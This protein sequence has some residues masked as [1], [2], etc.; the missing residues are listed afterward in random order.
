MLAFLGCAADPTYSASVA[1]SEQISTLVEVSYSPPEA[2]AWVE[3]EGQRFDGAEGRAVVYGAGPD[4]TLELTVHVGD[5]V[6]EPLVAQTGSLPVE[7]PP[8]TVVDDG[9]L[10][11]RFVLTSWLESPDEGSGVVVLDAAGRVVWYDLVEGVGTVAFLHKVDGGVLYLV[12]THSYLPE[13]H[14]VWLSDDGRD[15]VTY[16]LPMAHHEILPLPGGGFATLVGEARQVDGEDV[17]GDTIVEVAEDGTQRTIWNAFDHFEV[18]ENEGWGV[19]AYP[20]GADW[21]HANGLAYDEA[22][23]RYLVSILRCTCVVAVER[24]TGDIDFIVGGPDSDYAVDDAFGPQ[25]APGWTDDGLSMFDNGYDLGVSRLAEYTLA[26][27]EA[28]LRWQWQHPGG[29]VTAVLGDFDRL[30]DGS[31]LSSW[32]TL[33]EIIYVEA[34]D[35]LSWRVDVEPLHVLGQVEGFESFE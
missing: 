34:D 33:G 14:A 30:D 26:G 1:T 35:T 9:P 24:A 21:N 16:P 20:E 6:S 8:F 31:H 27:D 5:W 10:A 11:P 17:V 4:A 3:W 12:A 18:E 19:Q 15:R 25:H 7:I 22:T 2:E 13:A 32:G 28:T 29:Y 23:D